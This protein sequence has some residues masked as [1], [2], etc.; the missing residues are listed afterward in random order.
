MK[1]KILVLAAFSGLFFYS[2]ADKKAEPQVAENIVEEVKFDYVVDQF[3]D[4][5]ILRYQIP[6]FDEL[7]LDKQ[8]L[9]YYLTQ[10]F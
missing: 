8:K 1:L 4:L 10:L 3:A 9:V 6:G 5:R 2:C 7:S